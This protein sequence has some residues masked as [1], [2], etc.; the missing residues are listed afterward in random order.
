V[1]NSQGNVKNLLNYVK[2]HRIYVKYLLPNVKNL[3][4]F[5]QYLP[6]IVKNKPGI[7]QYL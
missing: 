6:E 3:L 1:N 4:N 5:V 2:Y 7:V